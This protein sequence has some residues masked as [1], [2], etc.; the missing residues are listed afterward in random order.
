VVTRIGALD[1]ERFTE[2]LAEHIDD[3]RD[4]ELRGSVLATSALMGKAGRELELTC[5][6]GDDHVV[7]L[8]IERAPPPREPVAFGH[9]PPTVVHSRQT[10]LEDGQ[11]GYLWFDAFLMPAPELYRDAMLDF[12]E[13]DVGG[14]IL[15]LRG[16]PG[17]LMG[18]ARGMAGHLIG[19]KTSLGKMTYRDPTFGPVQL[20]LKANPRLAAERYDGPVAVLVDR[21]TVSTGEVFAAGLQGVGRARGFGVRTPGMAMPSIM[22]E[23]PN[24]DTLQMPLGESLDPHG[25]RLEKDG[26]VPDEEIALTREAFAGNSDPIL[27]AALRWLAGQLAIDEEPTPPGGAASPAMEDTP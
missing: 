27:D 7:E 12:I 25:G 8:S 10:L 11:I 13:A 1:L 26:V 4:R 6:D 22:E 14:V 17:G 3:T 15:D 2:R 9:L 24:G 23:L 18:M 16:N 5:L 21:L 19:D 20:D